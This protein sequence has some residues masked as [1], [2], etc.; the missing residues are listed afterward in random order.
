MKKPKV[1]RESVRGTTF[2]VPVSKSEKDRIQ[3]IAARNGLTMSAWVRMVLAE[4]INQK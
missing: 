3:E 2:T 4:K 1:N